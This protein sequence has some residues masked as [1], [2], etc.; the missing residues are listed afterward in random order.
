MEPKPASSL[1]TAIFVTALLCGTLDAITPMIFYRIS[2]ARLF[3][4]I[5][6]GAFGKAALSGAM[7]TVLWGV[8]FHYFI[9]LSWT[10]LFFLV[11]PKF[12]LQNGNQFVIGLCYGIVIWLV[13]NLVVLP[14]SNALRGPVNLKS[15]LIGMMMLMIMVGLPIS[16]MARRF[17]SK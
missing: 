16:I 13:M 12:R 1:L 7:A 2:P 4:I 17:Y 6:T 15:V 9:A 5:A 14:L 10:A 3:Q 11:F 8:G